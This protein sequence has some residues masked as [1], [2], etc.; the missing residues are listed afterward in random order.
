[1]LLLLLSRRTVSLVVCCVSVL[2]WS[3]SFLK[4]SAQDGAHATARSTL[5]PTKHRQLYPQC[6]DL[7]AECPTRRN[8]CTSSDPKV[9]QWMHPHCPVTC[10]VCRNRTVTVSPKLSF[11]PQLFIEMDS[12]VDGTGRA[13][14]VPQIL[15]GDAREN[16]AMAR[17][18]QQSTEYY[19]NVVWKQVRYA[20]VRSLCR[21]QHERCAEYAVVHDRCNVDAYYDL[22]DYTYDDMMAECAV[23]CKKCEVLSPEAE[24]PY[25]PDIMKNAWYP[26]DVNAM[27]ERI[28]RDY[29]DLYNITILSRP[30]QDD[31]AD[32]EHSTIRDGP[33][34]ITLD[35]FLTPE[36]CQRLIDL[37]YDAGYER[38]EGMTIKDGVLVSDLVSNQ[39]T[40][41]NA[42]C[43]T[44]ACKRDP[45]ALSVRHR[46]ANLTQISP[47][48]SEPMQIL[49]YDPG[50]FYKVQKTMRNFSNASPRCRCFSNGL[51]M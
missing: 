25:N 10:N 27:F 32:V 2:T 8:D 14:G 43:D 41:R 45:I 21:N 9:R 47:M 48:H 33:W 42:W 50:E 51:A 3:D 26:G 36:E 40:S 24:C 11:S 38:S 31:S 35:G 13:I 15:S 17:K 34:V 44:A 16:R 19:H 29:D 49:K 39:R 23:I 1:M 12:M 7:R 46:M 5:S 37:G 4:A 6:N 18:I 28:V 30:L 20:T 22:D